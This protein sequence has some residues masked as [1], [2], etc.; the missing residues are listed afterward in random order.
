MEQ[1]D[2]VERYLKRIRNIYSGDNLIFWDDRACV[3]DDIFSFF[4]HCHHLQDWV[5]NLNKV[6][7]TSKQT[8]QFIEGHESLQIC[9]DLANQSKHCRLTKNPWSGVKP[10]LAGV[11]Y[12]SVGDS[13]S[14]GIRG[15]FAVVT[16]EATLDV[17]ELAESCW[18]HWRLLKHDIEQQWNAHN[19]AFK[20]DSQ[21]SAF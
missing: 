19:K 7:I 16:D 11:Q 1:F 2:R 17:L 6:G 5:S 3:E 20:R 10:H 14:P 4:I 9:A 13:N 18:C 21:R 12:E 8:K 15:K